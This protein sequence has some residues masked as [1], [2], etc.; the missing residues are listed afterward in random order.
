M[1]FNC[2]IVKQVWFHINAWSGIAQQNFSG[3]WQHFQEH[4]FSLSNRKGRK[5]K[6]VMWIA[7]VWSI[8][9]SRN[10]NVFKGGEVDII[11]MVQQIKFMT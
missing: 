9:I 11:S 10:N 8:W 2:G 1:F 7:I 6:H 5:I 4:K 3:I